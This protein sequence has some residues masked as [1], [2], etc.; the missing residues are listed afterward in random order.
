MRI[1]DDMPSRDPRVDA[2]IAK[3]ADFAR[4]ILTEIRDA[5][6][7]ACPDVDESIKWGAPHFSYNGM[8]CG[9]GAFKEHCRMHFWRGA[10]IV[11]ED[12]NVEQLHHIASVDELPSRATIGRYVKRAM[13]LN[14][15]RTSASRPKVAK[16][17]PSRPVPATPPALATA[18]RRNATAR[19]FFE[20]LPPSHK[21]D[22][23]EWI[24]EAKTE[25]TR[26]KRIATTIEWLAEGKSRNWKYEKQRA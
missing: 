6:H 18:L 7:A 20:S 24:T 3:S 13:Q 10:V 14:D 17:R 26:E 5:V 4:P 15:E 21:R 11:G 9:M 23:I 25:P 8:L 1:F 22:Y 12:R 2:Y 16:K 19:K